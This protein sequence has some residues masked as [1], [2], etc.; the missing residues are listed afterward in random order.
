MA[1]DIA[2]T[3]LQDLA[4]SKNSYALSPI[5]LTGTCTGLLAGGK[6]G[7]DDTNRMTNPRE[8]GILVHELRFGIPWIASSVPS[9]FG[10]NPFLDLPDVNLRVELSAGREYL[11]DSFVPVGL[12]GKTLNRYRQGYQQDP[13]Q[14][15]GGGFNFG[16]INCTWRLPK[17]M[18][19]PPKQS[20][21]PTFYWAPDWLNAT[22]QS[23]GSYPALPPIYFEVVGKC[24]SP[25]QGDP[26]MVNLLWASAWVDAPRTLTDAQALGQA[27]TF[28]S[29]QNNL[30]NPHSEPLFIQRLTGSYVFGDGGTNIGAVAPYSYGRGGIGNNLTAGAEGPTGFPQIGNDLTT[31]KLTGTKGQIIARDL[32]PWNHL[33]QLPQ[34]SVDIRAVMPP[35]G[36]YLLNGQLD[37]KTIGSN[38]YTQLAAGISGYRA[39]E[40]KGVL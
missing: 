37:T 27:A 33:F 25:E 10:T 36:Y 12:L 24:L 15:A 16:F 20:I 38:Y 21:L 11:T 30:R 34:N 19:L 6:L 35:R 26:E 4:S 5:T 3:A 18:Y 22:G 14:A 8:S 31:V 40:F 32:T 23:F 17:P 29:S 9:I 7:L 13:D 1:S 2:V 28:K 39:A